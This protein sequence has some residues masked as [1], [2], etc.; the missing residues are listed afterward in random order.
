MRTKR[1]RADE[2]SLF[3]SK[4][5]PPRGSAIPRPLFILRG[6]LW[7]DESHRS[8]AR[9]IGRQSLTQMITLRPID[10]LSSSR[11][12]RAEW[13]LMVVRVPRLWTLSIISGGTSFALTSTLAIHD[14]QTQ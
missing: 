2:T 8:F 9:I 4:R 7:K 13:S 10:H 12:P 1:R 5:K 3:T 11:H 6:F 14:C